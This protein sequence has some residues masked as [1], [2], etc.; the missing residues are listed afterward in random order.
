MMDIVKTG[1]EDAKQ[2]M[3]IGVIP[4]AIKLAV[5]FERPGFPLEERVSVAL[6]TVC[7]CANS[8]DPSRAKFTTYVAL[9]IYRNLQTAYRKQSKCL[10]EGIIEVNPTEHKTQDILF[11]SYEEN[12]LDR[13]ATKEKVDRILEFCKPRERLVI[14]SILDGLSIKE[15]SRRIGITTEC[16]RQTRER[17]FSKVRNDIRMED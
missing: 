4:W 6:E 2:S 8:F 10:D 13:I 9:P 16:F 14:Q 3:I 17:V 7:H 12:I 11:G 5:K 15:A 1:K